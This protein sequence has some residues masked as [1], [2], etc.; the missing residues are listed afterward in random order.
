MARWIEF[1]QCSRMK[2]YNRVSYPGVVDDIIISVK[3][4][5]DERISDEEIIIEWYPSF[6]K[7]RNLP[8]RKG[9]YEKQLPELL[10]YL[11][12]LREDLDPDEVSKKLT[13]LGCVD[14]S[15]KSL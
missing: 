15:D 14:G 5:R 7:V 3:S 8:S 1:L 10:P 4:D 6:L 12:N 2:Y 11:R 13:L 9:E